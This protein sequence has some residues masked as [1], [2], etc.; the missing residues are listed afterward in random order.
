[1]VLAGNASD[2]LAS[3]ANEAHN[4]NNHQ[5]P[6]VMEEQEQDKRRRDEDSAD[7]AEDEKGAGS[8]EESSSLQ[9]EITNGSST[10]LNCDNTSTTGDD[11]RIRS[12]DGNGNHAIVGRSNHSR[13][14]SSSGESNTWSERDPGST[15]SKALSSLL[16]RRRRLK[17]V[18]E[19]SKYNVLDPARKERW[20]DIEE[21]RQRAAE[22][23]V[24]RKSN[25]T[26]DY[27]ECGG[28]GTMSDKYRW[29]D[30]AWKQL[31][32]ELVCPYNYYHHYVSIGRM[33]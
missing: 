6:A 17:D 10:I 31:F 27:S 16:K 20:D 25:H 13:S 1:M 30:Q 4:N 26:S 22:D 5:A 23:D 33:C 29:S 2:P 21:L 18:F 28:Y 32:E 12:D 8:R 3:T 15:L 24:Q 11:I 19:F 7:A 14:S 9:G